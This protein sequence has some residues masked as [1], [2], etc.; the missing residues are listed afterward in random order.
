MPRQILEIPGVPHHQN[1]IP[2]GV[3][4]GNMVFSSAIS[5]YDP[6]TGEL[7]A[8]PA[9]QIRNV[10]RNCRAMVEQAGGTVNDIAKMSVAM[11][12]LSLRK[13]VN[14]EWLAMF[15]TDDRPARHT[16]E[17]PINER[18]HIQIELIAVLGTQA[19]HSL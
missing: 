10:F 19:A 5:G 2:Q 18:F 4:I 8:D 12:D 16:V 15:P 1:P 11:R 13:F 17:L 6:D 9:A 14:E 7:P 3:R